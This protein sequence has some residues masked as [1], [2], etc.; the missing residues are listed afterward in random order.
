MSR[1]FFV[2]C[3]EID[4]IL[5]FIFTFAKKYIKINVEGLLINIAHVK[6]KKY[7][8]ITHFIYLAPSHTRVCSRF[9]RR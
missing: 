5:H 4:V 6:G 8:K 7:E 9:V 3:D 1:I 2:I